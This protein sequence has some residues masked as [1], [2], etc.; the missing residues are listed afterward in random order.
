MAGMP[1]ISEL[2]ENLGKLYSSVATVSLDGV[3]HEIPIQYERLSSD[4]MS[5]EQIADR[6]ADRYH[7]DLAMRL[8]EAIATEKSKLVD[9]AVYV[10][11]TSDPNVCKIGIASNP[12]K[13][14]AGLQC[15]RHDEIN[16]KALFWSMDGKAQGLEQLSLRIAS[17]M[18]LRLK[19]E[20]VALD[21]A[22][23]TTLI[24]AVVASMASPFADSS[25]WIRNR[26]AL[27]ES[28]RLL[29]E[30]RN[31][32]AVPSGHRIISLYDD[33]LALVSGTRGRSARRRSGAQYT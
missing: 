8:A 22:G 18:G 26:K 32:N 20:W 28:K 11:G 12:S 24:S 31:D 16:V 33:P 15:A 1:P 4:R 30:A 10:I 9:S 6:A 29:A 3:E 14:L 13:R 17:K 23:A 25:M 19:G 5:V 2:S 27:S 21:A 7:N